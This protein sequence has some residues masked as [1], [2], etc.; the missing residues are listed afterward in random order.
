MRKKT[1]IFFIAQRFLQ[2]QK[3][4]SQRFISFITFFSVAGVALG[5]TALIITLTI[6]AGFEKELKEKIFSFT[7][8]V[9][10]T[11]F[12]NRPLTNVQVTKNKILKAN[13]TILTANPYVAKEAMVSFND[14]ADGVFIKGIVPEGI[15]EI[16]KYIVEGEIQFPKIDDGLYSCIIGKKLLQNLHASL[17]DTLIGFGLPS[18]FS[19]SVQPRIIGFVVTGI[20]ESGMAEYD[21]VFLY[22]SIEAAQEIFDVQNTVTGFDVSLSDPSNAN[23]IAREL[24]STLGF[25]FFARSIFQQY[26]NLFTWI[27]LQKEPIPIVLGL[28]TLV[29]AINIIGTLLM[30]VLEKKK[31][32]GVLRSLGAK[33]KDIKK[34]F[35]VQGFLVAIS[36]TVLGNIVGF[37]ICWIQSEFQILTLPSSIYFMKSVPILF[38]P[39]NFIIVSTVSII[40]C[41][42]ASYI[43]ARL[44][45]TLDP[46][47]AIRQ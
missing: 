25:P 19:S 35:I 30:L 6:L 5:V 20:Y 8:H 32:I 18:E 13:N 46:I 40:L 17:H 45:S 3:S 36:G 41:V 21:D 9:Q 31:Q 38:V 47:K 37:S 10:V 27:Q 22:T 29:A 42:L 7:A 16:Q 12:Q 44:A 11:A 23:D 33:R 43:P 34:I 4:Q 14:N 26:K 24:S 2:T 1:Y 15:H 39:E 28:I